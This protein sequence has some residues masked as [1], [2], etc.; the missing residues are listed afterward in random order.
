MIFFHKDKVN[1][2]SQYPCINYL[3]NALRYINDNNIEDAYNEICYAIIKSGD[4]LSDK[5]EETF[6]N[7][8]LKK[9]GRE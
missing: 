8:L 7:N 6:K 3:H 2:L 5:E 9:E 4:K 1:N